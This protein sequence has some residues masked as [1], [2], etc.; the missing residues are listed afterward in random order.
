MHASHST[1]AISNQKWA[2]F[3]RLY[4]FASSHFKQQVFLWD[5]CTV[6]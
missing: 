5:N 2:Q 4:Q 1:V 3:A 6:Y